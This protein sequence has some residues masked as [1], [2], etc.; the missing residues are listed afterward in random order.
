MIKIV[1]LATCHNRGD[2]TLSSLKALS[3]QAFDEP[4][5]LDIVLVDDGST[6][7][8]VARVNNYYSEVKIVKGD[9]TLFW[10]GGMR[11]GW[12]SAV[13]KQSFDYLFVYND[14]CIFA[15]DAIQTLLNDV[16]YIEKN[17]K[18]AGLL[19]AGAFLDQ[20]DAE[21]SYGGYVRN[22]KFNPLRFKR[23]APRDDRPC[24][25]DTINMNGCLIQSKLL[26]K[27]GFLEEYFVHGGADLEFGLRAER[28][29]GECYQSSKF[30]GVCPRNPK[31]YFGV[32]LLNRWEKATSVKGQPL[33]QRYR[34]YKEYGG[35]FW[36]FYFIRYYFKV[37]LPGSG[38]A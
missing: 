22:S 38:K 30:I 25:V 6:D 4:V 15:P 10:A 26:K 24:R 37:V 7:D 28:E 23:V 18:P 8:T 27:I 13:V 33:F 19:V 17:S 2:M 11:F 16:R 9:G 14:D 36:L 12:K 34:F 21:L 5:N 32:G 3:E 1:A 35:S 20:R 31:T 29:G